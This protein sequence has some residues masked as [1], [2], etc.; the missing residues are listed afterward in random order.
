[1]V[2]ETQMKLYMKESDFLK[3]FSLPKKLGRM[4]QKQGFLNLWK[5]WS[6]ICSKFVLNLVWI[7]SWR[8]IYI[9]CCVPAQI[10]YLGKFLFLRNGPKCSQPVRLHDFL[11]NQVSR[12]NQWI[13]T[14]ICMLMQ[15]HVI[16]K[17]DQKFFGVGMVKNWCGHTVMGL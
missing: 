16:K 14:I 11:I 13:S 17:F 15:I 12:T 2:L 3:N 9:I 10:P 4:G 6:L 5:I 8:K 7:Y 1:M